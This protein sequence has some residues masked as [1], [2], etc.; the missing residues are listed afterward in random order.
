MLA[1]REKKNRTKKPAMLS[2][3]AKTSMTELKKKSPCTYKHCVRLARLADKFAFVLRLNDIERVQL[4]QGCYLHD[5]GKLSTPSAILNQEGALNE[6]EWNTM[7]KHPV[8]G[9]R[10]AK[11][12]YEDIDNRT[13]ETIRSHHERWDGGGYPDGLVS[14]KI[15]YFA[16]ICAIL[17]AYDSMVSD[18]CY[19]K[20][21]SIN[22]AIVEL[23]R[24]SG[25][26]FDPNLVHCFIRYCV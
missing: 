12:L 8:Q 16:R 2:N 9:A 24:N 26:Q 14:E 5:I 17:D 6:H 21:L 15:P 3:Y 4:I 23:K 25:T 19:R 20:G 7:K 11:A 1:V 13:L 10:I 18:R 22:Q